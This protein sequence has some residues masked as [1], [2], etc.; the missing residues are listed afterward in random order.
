MPK[1][2]RQS[3]PS[4]FLVLKQLN[5]KQYLFLLLD[6]CHASENMPRAVHI[7][8]WFSLVP[9]WL[10][11]NE[12]IYLVFRWSSTLWSSC[13]LKLMFGYVTDQFSLRR[14]P[15]TSDLYDEFKSM[16]RSFVMLFERLV[17]RKVKGTNLQ[18]ISLV[19]FV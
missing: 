14:S 1:A 5:E 15:M 8:A 6:Y 10:N 9:L 13:R 3:F 19:F 4:L 18:V 11:I 17:D 7:F 16:Y 12:Q 2:N